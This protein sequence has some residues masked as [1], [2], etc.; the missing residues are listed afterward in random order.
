MKSGNHPQ[1]GAISDGY[2]HA[3][4]INTVGG[5]KSEEKQ[6]D[7]L[8]MFDE[9]NGCTACAAWMIQERQ[10]ANPNLALAR[11]RSLFRAL[12]VCRREGRTASSANDLL[13]RDYLWRWYCLPGVLIAR[14]PSSIILSPFSCIRAGS[15]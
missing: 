6:I 7:T 14:C 5:D 8:L 1:Y 9:G 4:E 15:A 3:H 11:P 10:G 13:N 12:C 2:P